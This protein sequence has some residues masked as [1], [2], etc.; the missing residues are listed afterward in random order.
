[1]PLSDFWRLDGFLA[2]YPPVDLLVAVYLGVK[3]TSQGV[4]GKKTSKRDAV[5]MN[6]EALAQMPVRKNVKTIDQMP[7]FLRTPEQLALIEGM[8]KEWSSSV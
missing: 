1:M 8:K 6:T 7:A 3:P 4:T 2:E 5:R